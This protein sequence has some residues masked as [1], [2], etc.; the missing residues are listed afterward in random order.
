MTEQPIKTTE[1]QVEEQV[2]A[3]NILKTDAQSTTK[4]YVP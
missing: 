4:D 2:I 1:D 3:L